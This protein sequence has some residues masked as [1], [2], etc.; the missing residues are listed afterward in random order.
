MQV[1]RHR[2]G[3]RLGE[4]ATGVAFHAHDEAGAEVVLKILRAERNDDASG[5]MSSRRSRSAGT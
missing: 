4:G 5:M 3:A 2:L 1:G